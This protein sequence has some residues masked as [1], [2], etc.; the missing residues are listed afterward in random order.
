MKKFIV[1]GLVVIAIL[2]VGIACYSYT[3]NE[4]L[5]ERG[6]RVRQEFYRAVDG[7]RLFKCFP[8]SRWN[9]SE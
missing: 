6:N 2:L 5:K 3:K 8:V 4:E 1:A 7:E 9:R